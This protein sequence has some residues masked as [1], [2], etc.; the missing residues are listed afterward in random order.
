MPQVASTSAFAAAAA[1]GGR[2]TTADGLYPV[3][4]FEQVCAPQRRMHG[5]SSGFNALLCVQDQPKPLQSQQYSLQRNIM[6]LPHLYTERDI[7]PY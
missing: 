2:S 7:G 4:H 5:W 6:N 1:S 3:L